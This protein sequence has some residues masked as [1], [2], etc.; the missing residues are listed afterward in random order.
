M[1]VMMMSMSLSLDRMPTASTPS[2]AKMNS[3]LPARM[4]LR[5]LLMTSGLRSGSSSTISILLAT[6]A[7]LPVESDLGSVSGSM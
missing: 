5:I 2:S 7:F 3:Y 1:S 4:S 6:I